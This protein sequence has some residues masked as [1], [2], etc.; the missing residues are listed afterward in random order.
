MDISYS[1]QRA[2]LKTKQKVH[3]NAWNKN[4]RS[5]RENWTELREV[6]NELD[7]IEIEVKK[8][9]KEFADKNIPLPPRKELKVILESRVFAVRS[10]EE[11]DFKEYF[12][13]YIEFQSRR[14]NPRTGKP[15]SKAT[16][17]A[18]K[19]THDKLLD[20]E[21]RTGNFISF[22]TLSNSLYNSLISYFEVELK[23]RPNT[24]GKHIKN[25]KSVIN[26][27]K[28]ID[29]I[30]LSSDY[31]EKYWEVPQI[32]KPAE[33]LVFV[34]EADLKELELMDLS[35]NT[36]YE[37]AR[38]IFLIG[39]W[40]A[41]RINRIAKLTIDHFDLDNNVINI[42][43]PKTDVLLAIPI[44]PVVN[45]IINKYG[46]V[47]PKLSEPTV[48]KALKELCKKIE[49]LNQFIKIRDIVG[50]VE[51]E[52]VYRKYEMVTIHCSR[53]SFASNMYRRRVPIQEIMA[54]TG[55]T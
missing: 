47:A 12:K 28:N 55:H 19:Q 46:G 4:S 13:S 5:I 23:F 30:V 43:A 21:K 49:S 25:I 8:V 45:K 34:S 16:I 17:D 31:K 44:H 40:T 26:H 9:I 18:Y 1:G 6:Q 48:N 42:Q 27:A 24:V 11:L 36:V 35:Y 41:L 14:K 15:I 20:F 51:K 38:D 50:N 32:I 37:K 33:E 22:L 3:P 29:G 2:K 39:A 10:S 53:R 54:V 52:R 7:R